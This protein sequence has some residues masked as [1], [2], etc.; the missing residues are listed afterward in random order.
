MIWLQLC[1]CRCGWGQ[2]RLSMSALVRKAAPTCTFSGQRICMTVL[3]G[4]IP[5]CDKL[6]IAC[7][8]NPSRG[9]PSSP[10]QACL[11]VPC[12]LLWAPSCIVASCQNKS[13]RQG[14]A[15]SRLFLTWR[16]AGHCSSTWLLAGHAW[17]QCTLRGTGLRA[18]HHLMP[19]PTARA[20]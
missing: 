9:Y 5:E 17:L 18:F 4:W 6:L 11:L 10:C 13:C 1:I 12:T 16:T 14:A 3:H 20:L 8:Q 15:T 7:L 2:N 19:M